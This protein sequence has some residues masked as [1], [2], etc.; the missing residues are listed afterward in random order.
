MGLELGWVCF[1]SASG[2]NRIALGCVFVRF[3]FVLG[4]L[5][6]G[7]GLLWLGL[8]LLGVVF[9]F[10]L[11]W[12]WFSLG[13]VGFALGWVVFAL[14]WVGHEAVIRAVDPR[15]LW[16]AG[17]SSSQSVDSPSFSVHDPS[18]PELSEGALE[19]P[20][21]EALP[22]DMDKF[23][24]ACDSNNSA[25]VGLDLPPHRHAQRCC[26]EAAYEAARSLYHVLFA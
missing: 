25:N 16:S 20:S 22:E 15:R 9:G 21:E 3:V 1:G 26:P 12:V 10:P 13:Q 8:A 2:L 24:Y 23:G 14:G 7:L 4:F 5:W 18:S 6:A 19:A 17:V 11:G